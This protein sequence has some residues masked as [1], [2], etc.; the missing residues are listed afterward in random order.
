LTDVKTIVSGGFG[1][2]SLWN[3]APH[4]NA[5]RVFVNWIASKEGTGIYASIDGSAP[6]RTDLDASAWLEPSLIPKPGGDYFDV[7]DYK[8]VMEQRQP[9]ARF[10]A[11]LKG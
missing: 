6:V 9:I 8:Y 2:V 1:V 7:Y 3:K 11:G 5:A 10:Y 4:P